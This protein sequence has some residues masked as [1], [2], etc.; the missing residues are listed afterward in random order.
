MLSIVIVLSCNVIGFMQRC[1]NRYNNHGMLYHIAIC[2][3]EIQVIE[4]LSSYLEKY[5]EMT[6]DTYALSTYTDGNAFLNAYSLTTD[7]I[8]LDIRMPSIDGISVAREIRRKDKSVAIIF[9]TSMPEY[10]LEGFSVHASGYLVKPVVYED[11][12]EEITAARRQIRTRMGSFLTL[13]S[14]DGVFRINTTDIIYIDVM[15]HTLFIHL[16]DRKIQCY[17]TLKSLEEQL[18]KDCFSR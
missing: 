18:E 12:A 4:K 11:L 15:N 6:G 10:A 3:D 2:D 1:Q 7:L 13:N 17:G 8:F 16:N 5:F 14:E 9:I